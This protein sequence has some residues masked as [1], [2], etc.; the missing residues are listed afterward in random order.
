MSQLGSRDGKRERREAEPALERGAERAGEEPREEKPDRRSGQGWPSGTRG[1]PA[2]NSSVTRP[3]ALCTHLILGDGAGVE[4]CVPGAGQQRN[5]LDGGEAELPGPPLLPPPPQVRVKHQQL[6]Q[7]TAKQETLIKPSVCIY[8]F[9]YPSFGRTSLA[10]LSWVSA[11]RAPSPRCSSR[12]E[13]AQVADRD[14]PCTTS[15]FLQRINRL[16]VPSGSP[17][18]HCRLHQ[19]RPG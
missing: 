17:R 12:K 11:S 10:R 2:C 7:E 14:T 8:A 1:V 19:A 3:I 15:S 9:S 13:R 6:G 18:A 5:V 16:T 4:L